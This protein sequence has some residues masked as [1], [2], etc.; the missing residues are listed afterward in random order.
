MHAIIVGCGRVGSALTQQLSVAGHSVCVI[1]RDDD[2]FERLPDTLANVTKINGYGFDRE[3]LQRAGIDN[4]A[5][6]AAVTSGDNTNIMCARVARE[7]FGLKNVVARIYDPRRAGLY[8]RLG[9]PT[10]ATVQWATDQIMRRLLVDEEVAAWT[11]PSGTVS[12]VERLLPAHLAGTQLISL[13]RT[14][15]CTV[16]GV[17]RYGKAMLVTPELVGQDGDSIMFAID[18]TAADVLGSVL[19]GDHQ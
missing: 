2:A 7:T 1:D 16:V 9:I 8:Q 4:A 5:A 13:N 14:S 18:N 11:D 17:T 12:V 15:S 3:T 6:Y 19:A 10:V